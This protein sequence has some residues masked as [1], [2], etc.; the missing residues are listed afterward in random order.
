VHYRAAPDQAAAARRVAA[1]ARGLSE[2]RL[3]PGKCVL[4]LVPAEAPH[5]GEALVDACRRLRCRRALFL[6]DDVTDED[7]FRM[8]RPAV[9]LLGIRVGR[10]VRSKASFYV[11]GQDEVD[12]LLRRLLALT[13]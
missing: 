8:K 7:V 2:V 5:K 9:K 10:S 12:E 1:S 13:T 11:R 6:G 3:V 4:N